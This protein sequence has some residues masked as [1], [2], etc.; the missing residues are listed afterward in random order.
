MSTQLIQVLID[1]V[2]ENRKEIGLMR[3]DIAKLDKDVFS[4][5]LR[6]SVFIG[7][8]SLFSSIVWVIISEKIKT[9]M[10]A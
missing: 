1:E 4:N 9:Y 10:G 6:L 2:R 5:K 8:V 7:G 3:K